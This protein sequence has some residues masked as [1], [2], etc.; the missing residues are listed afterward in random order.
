MNGIA[1]KWRQP[2]LDF[3]QDIPVN[4]HP[5]DGPASL[6]K[7]LWHGSQSLLTSVN[8]FQNQLKEKIQKITSCNKDEAQTRPTK[9]APLALV[10]LVP[11]G[12]ETRSASGTQDTPETHATSETPET[13]GTPKT[14]DTT[15]HDEMGDEVSTSTFENTD[16]TNTTPGFLAAETRS[17]HTPEEFA[18]ST[19]ATGPSPSTSAPHIGLNYRSLK[20][21]G[22]VLI[23]L[24]LLVW[25]I[26]RWKDPRWRVDRAARRE[27]RRNK[28]L[29]KRAARKHMIKTW[30]W[31]FRMKFKLASDDVLSWDEKRARVSG[32][33]EVLENVMK[34]DIR[35]LRNAHRIVSNITAAEEGRNEFEYGAESSERR[36]SVATLPGY[37]SEGSQ[38]PSYEASRSFEGTTLVEGST[39]TPADVDSNPDSS[40]VSTSPRISRDGTNSE[41]DEKIEAL[42]LDPNPATDDYRVYNHV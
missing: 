17:L 13:N 34:N 18:Y 39:F 28:R 7:T 31:N 20:V 22:L 40:V 36:R 2:S 1:G 42:S 25:S 10:P 27:E 9:M 41:F 15:D 38:P 24:S 4:S 5:G 29:Y 3:D 23:L 35:A 33:E 30:L 6:T 16:S 12:N 8:A 11:N 26:L 21:F 14:G 19:S 37:E 32:Q